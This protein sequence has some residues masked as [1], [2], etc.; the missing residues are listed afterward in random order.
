[1]KS[2]LLKLLG[3]TSDLANVEP[4]LALF[5]GAALLAVFLSAFL[6]SESSTDPSGKPSLLWTLYRHF[7]HLAKALALVA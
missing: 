1:M 3:R 4:L 5:L 2:I 6:Q 7:T